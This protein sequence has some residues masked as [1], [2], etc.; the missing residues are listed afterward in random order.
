MLENSLHAAVTLD[1]V[2]APDLWSIKIDPTQFELALLNLVINA[3]DAIAGQGRITI[4]AGNHVE[5]ASKGPLAAGAYVRIRVVDNGAGMPPEVLARAFDPFFTTKPVDKGSGLGL[6]QAYGFAMQSGGTLRLDSSVGAGTT[7]SLYLPR[8]HVAP[9]VPPVQ[10]QHPGVP[11]LKATVLFVEDDSLVRESVAPILEEAG[12]TVLCAQDAK[13]ALRMIE[14]GRHIDVLFSDIVM[15]G[16]MNGVM[17]AEHVRTKYPR[18]AVVLAT[19]YF[20]KKV[21]LP[22]V[23]LLAKP[24]EAQAA[25]D[26][27]AHAV[28]AHTSLIT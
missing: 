5:T 4:E 12:A 28:A 2:I 6:A 19:G 25:I 24:Y 11:V 10:P 21:E 16:E 17:L 13:E 14:S 18:I 3:R 7:A 27:L 22:G 23:R 26:A 1:M 15:P 20:E 8:E 9:A